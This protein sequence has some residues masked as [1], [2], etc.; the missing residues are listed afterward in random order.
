MRVMHEWYIKASR[1][2]FGFIS[3]TVPEGAFMSGPNEIFFISFRDLYTLYKLDK[4][5]VNL[6]AAFCL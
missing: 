3:V 6:V 4:M 2:G 1:K 5:D